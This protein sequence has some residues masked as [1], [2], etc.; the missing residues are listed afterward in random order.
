MERL[1]KV[2]AAGGVTSRRKAETLIKEG[3]VRVNGEI[4]R[5]LGTKVSSDDVV[6]VDGKTV[7]KEPPI[8]YVFYKPEGCVSTTEDEKGRKTVLDYFDKDARIFPV[9]RLDYD[10]SGILLLS[11]D[12]TFTQNMLH[13]S[14]QIE[15]E[16]EVTMTGFLRRETSKKI[17]KGIMLDGTLTAKTR[18]RNVKSDPKKAT[19]KLNIIVTEGRYHLVK[20]L[21]ASFDHE[22]I[23]LKRI[24]F[25]TVTLD[26]L[27][28]GD[29]RLLK[30]HEYKQLMHLSNH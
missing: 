29:V 28:R 26:G 6:S 21:F 1:Q 12:G 24:R 23:K 15:K 10:T 17:E 9:G 2:I 3:R 19:T 4:V 27:A 30:P 7:H 13:P 22:V 18:I 5:T 25:G 8:H 16:Y 20:R 14:R 11:N